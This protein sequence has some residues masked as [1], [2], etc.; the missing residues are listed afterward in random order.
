MNEIDEAVK[1]IAGRHPEC[2][3]SLFFGREHNSK[4]Q[5]VEDAHIQIPEHR[6]DKVW[7]IHDGKQEGCL[8][9]EAILQPARR[10]LRRLN[11]KNAAAQVFFK[12]PIITVLVYLQRG[13]YATF[14]EGY[15]EELGG[16]RNDHRFARILLWE[17][18][19]R[20][21]SGEL[22]E[23]APFLTLL[24]KDPG[25]EILQQMNTIIE[26][27]AD[28]EQRL[29]LKSLGAIVAART[30]SEE[31]IKQYLTLE[32]AMIRETTIFSEWLDQA[33]TKGQVE[34]YNEGEI[35][36]K[37]ILLQKLL[38]RKF[39][40]LTAELALSLSKLRS[41]DLEALTAVILDLQS[42]DE[43]RAW[44]QSFQTENSARSLKH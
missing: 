44:L 41:E 14:P 7:R 23:L 13:E 37:H 26:T 30:F 4:L 3:M 2:F 1:R 6:A 42:L 40:L 31:L 8:L 19:E 29:E 25:P 12:V 33:E 32:L 18:A 28:P 10:D 24:E 20:I 38:E 22:K 21:R 34:G 5:G 17:H 36:G 27:V 11:L 43:L 35:K 9:L 15:E 16:M 39:G